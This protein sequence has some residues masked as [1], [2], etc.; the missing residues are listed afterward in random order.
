MILMPWASTGM[1]LFSNMPG[2]PLA[3]IIRGTSGP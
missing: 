2:L 3:P 1:I